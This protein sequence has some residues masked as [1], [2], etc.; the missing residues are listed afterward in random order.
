M[1]QN[2]EGWSGLSCRSVNPSYPFAPEADL[3]LKLLAGMVGKQVRL[4]HAIHS[5]RFVMRCP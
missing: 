5:A 2:R 4:L 1:I 3:R